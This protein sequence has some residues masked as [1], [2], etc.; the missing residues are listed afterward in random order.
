MASDH[1]APLNLGNDRLISINGLVDLI[2][3][4]AG[5]HLVKRHLSDRPQ[6]VRGRNSDNALLRQVLAWEPSISLEDGLQR[7]YRWIEAQLGEP[8]GVLRKA[9]VAR[10]PVA[11]L[12]PTAHAH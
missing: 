8:R 12:P 10:P 7:T 9:A 11:P 4:I 5:K 6:G 1:S 3:G 2:C